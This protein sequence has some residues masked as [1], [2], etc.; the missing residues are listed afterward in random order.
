MKIGLPS[1]KNV[2]MPLAKSILILLGLAA[3]ASGKNGAIQKEIYGSRM[4]TSI[5]F[6]DKSI[7]FIYKRC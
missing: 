5:R 6:T 7:R 3:A 2:L 1:M 4:T